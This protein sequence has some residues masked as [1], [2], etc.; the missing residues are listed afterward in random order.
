MNV[1]HG[2]WRWALACCALA[3]SAAGLRADMTVNEAFSAARARLPGEAF[4]MAWIPYE[5]PGDD[6]E[7][8]ACSAA[9]SVVFSKALYGAIQ[10]ATLRPV[11]VVVAGP[12]SAHSRLVLVGATRLVHHMLPNL[13]VLFI[14]TGDDTEIARSAIEKVGGVLVAPGSRT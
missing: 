5:D 6:A 3:A 1:R 13:R 12:N 4:M 9:N 7:M 2:F 11:T 8:Q 14:G 10:P